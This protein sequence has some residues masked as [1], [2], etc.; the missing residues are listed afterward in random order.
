MLC[1]P[2]LYHILKLHNNG[3]DV[4]KWFN[5]LD[6][7][8][9]QI[10]GYGTTSKQ[11]I[12]YFYQKYLILLEN[13]F[14]GKLNIKHELSGRLTPEDI[15]S[16][17][18]NC[19]QITY[20]VTDRC[21]LECR[22]CGYGKFYGNYDRRENK[23]LSV[24]TAKRFLNFMVKLM[25]SSLNKSQ[26]RNTYISFYG[27]E[28]LLNFPFIRDIVEYVKQLKVLHNRFTFSMTTNAILIEKYM[29]FLKKH[30]F[31]L[32]ISLD[33]DEK[34]NSYRVFKDGTPAYHHILRNVMALKNQYPD[35]F[36][37]KVNFNAV[38]H[39]KNS[40]SDIHRYFKNNFDKIPSIGELN[41]TGI[42][43]SQREEF[44]K[45]YANINENLMQAENCSLFE[46]EM[47]MNLPNIQGVAMFIHQYS[48]FMYPSYN[49]L[50]FS[51]EDQPRIPTGTCSP[52][53]KK[54]HITVNGKILPCERIGQ[55]YSLGGAAGE[56][57]ELDFEKVAAVYNNYYD[58]LKK[59]CLCCSNAEICLH[60]IFN[61]NLEDESSACKAFTNETSFSK[62]L[63]SQMSYL[64]ENP[65]IY[66]RI[67]KEVVI[68]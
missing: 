16:N 1:D 66:S 3:I 56:K 54:V 48:G 58:K 20:E 2:I 31:D 47:F 19:K 43:A 23:N 45:T 34:N 12:G 37:R 25:N 41:T 27:G 51:N 18:A 59:H 49:E 30:D 7:G 50:V 11:A 35:Y 42:K 22:Y 52:F 36:K 38:F 21:Q 63:S 10:D 17:L 61:L 13:G 28:P 4:K 33:G 32:L 14:F 60:C 57:V 62:A 9:I 24:K 26:D 39:N 6:D 29:D 53:S 55:Q 67:M 5:G 65:K 46:K 15:K 8:A 40:I 68:E 64:E 44:R